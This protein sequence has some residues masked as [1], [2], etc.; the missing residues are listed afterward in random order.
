[1]RNEGNLN[2]YKNKK[3][4]YKGRIYHS[5]LE[6][7][8]A[9]WLDSLQRAGKIK[10][11][12]RQ[13]RLSID[14]NGQHICNLYVDFKI[15]LPDGRQKYAEIKGFPT[16]EWKLKQKLALVLSPIPYLVNPDLR[17]LLE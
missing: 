8:S 6:A 10:D 17:T 15:T 14:I 4:R 16:A 3:C 12:E 2:K 5:R 11:I 9:L 13:S 1:M 7:G